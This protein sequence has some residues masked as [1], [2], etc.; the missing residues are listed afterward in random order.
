MKHIKG[1]VRLL[2]AT[3]YR[4]IHNT[5]MQINIKVNAQK[6]YY[7]A[8]I[9]KKKAKLAFFIIANKTDF[10]AKNITKI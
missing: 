1:S 10:K 8:N 5:E 7:Y 3:S 2:S 4:L 6:I 9:N